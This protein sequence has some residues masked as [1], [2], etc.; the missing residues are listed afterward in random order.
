MLLDEY[1]QK[2]EGFN[3]TQKYKNELAMLF[4]LV[5]AMPND[6]ICDIGCGIGTAVNTFQWRFPKAIWIGY[7]V[8]PLY[9]G[10][11]NQIPNNLDKA[12]FMHSFSH[13]HNMDETLKKLHSCLKKDGEIV[14]ITPNPEWIWK[15][16]DENY[17]PDETVVQHYTMTQ[18]K[19]I[20]APYFEIMLIGQFDSD[21]KK[22]QLFGQDVLNERIFVKAT[23]K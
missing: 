12:Y 10:A 20:L 1:K 15:N 3:S 5:C 22:I 13:I 8:N 7:D 19:E 21:N 2:L 4:N 14:I 11:L 17:K 18:L 23:K 6:K 16:Q 9:S